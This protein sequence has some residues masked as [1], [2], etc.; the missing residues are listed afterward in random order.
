VQS[1]AKIKGKQ[2]GEKLNFLT[3]L[4]SGLNELTEMFLHM[5]PVVNAELKRCRLQW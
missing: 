5:S 2:G 4:I 1:A 3:N